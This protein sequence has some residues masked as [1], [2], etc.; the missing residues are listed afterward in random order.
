[1]ALFGRPDQPTPLTFVD[2]F[3]LFAYF[4]HR[5]IKPLFDF[6]LQLDTFGTFWPP[7]SADTPDFCRQFLTFCIFYLDLGTPWPHQLQLQIHP[8]R[9][10]PKPPPLQSLKM[11]I[12]LKES[13]KK[14]PCCRRPVN[15]QFPASD[16]PSSEAPPH[17]RASDCCICVGKGGWDV[18]AH[19][20]TSP[21]E[22]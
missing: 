19:L 15:F 14:S 2:S 22:P 6:R 3:T 10:P 18:S 16:P 11:A 20:W 13:N 8:P 21:Q 12:S 17:F 5:S 7:R 4:S 9:E 1:M